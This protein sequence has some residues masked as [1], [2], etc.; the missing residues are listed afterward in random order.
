MRNSTK[1][2]RYLFVQKAMASGRADRKTRA[3]ALVFDSIK[4][5]TNFTRE[6]SESAEKRAM[7]VK[8]RLRRASS[9]MMAVDGSVVEKTLKKP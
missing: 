3:M 4:Q 9:K 7:A 6:Q 5:N 2:H 1:F 8:S